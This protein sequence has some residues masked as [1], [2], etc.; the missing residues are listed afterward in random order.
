MKRHSITRCAST[1]RAVRRTG[2]LLKQFDGHGGD[3]SK[4]RGRI[5]FC[6][7][8]NALKSRSEQA[9]RGINRKQAVRVANVPQDRFDA[10]VDAEKPATVT[11]LAEMDKQI[12]FL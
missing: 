9:F 4:R 1:G 10:A 6:L 2:E 7:S 12:R 3:Q 11:A 5:P 8:A